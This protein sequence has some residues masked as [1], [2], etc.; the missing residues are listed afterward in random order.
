MLTLTTGDLQL[1]KRVGNYE[2]CEKWEIEWF[3][4]WKD[5]FSSSKRKGNPWEDAPETADFN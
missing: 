1:G 5:A 4:P 2:N 3:D